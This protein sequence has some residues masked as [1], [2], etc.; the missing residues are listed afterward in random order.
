MA[1]A[2]VVHITLV[3]IGPT[4]EIITEGQAINAKVAFSTEHRIM[5]KESVPNSSSY[6]TIEAFIEA[7]AADGFILNHLSQYMVVTTKQ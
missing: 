5:P 6:P 2:H 3:K 7:E 4:G 1:T